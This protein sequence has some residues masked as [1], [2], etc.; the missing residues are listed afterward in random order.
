MATLPSNQLKDSLFKKHIDFS[1][2]AF[3]IILMQSGFA[4]NRASHNVYA[5]V[6]G[7]ELP[8][9]SG[10]TMGGV[11][12]AGAAVTRDDVANTVTVTWNNPSWLAVGGDI[13]TQGAIIIDDTVAVPIVDPVVGYIDFGSA[14]T[15]FDTGN[16]TVSAPTVVI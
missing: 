3:I 9:A 15:T 6:L 1:G 7:S 5:D 4:F 11:T 13:V 2:D 8:T 10:Y 14:L 12:L 16:F